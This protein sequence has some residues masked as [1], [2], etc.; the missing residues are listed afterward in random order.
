MIYVMNEQN[1]THDEKTIKHNIPRNITKTM[2][3]RKSV[4]YNKHGKFVICG[5]DDW[6]KQ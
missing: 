2:I 3:C 6:T 5:T 1:I 4:N